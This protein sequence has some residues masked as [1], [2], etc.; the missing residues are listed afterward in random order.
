MQALQNLES[1]VQDQMMDETFPSKF[2]KFQDEL[3]HALLTQLSDIRPEV[4]R[5]GAQTISKLAVLLGSSFKHVAR[6]TL[7][8]M[9]GI[10][11]SSQNENIRS[12]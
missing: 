8:T 10:A 4:L 11:C 12:I 2:E 9:I 1:L 7:I 5:Q 6:A 3:A